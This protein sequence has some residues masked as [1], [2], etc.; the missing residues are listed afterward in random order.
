MFRKHE[1]IMLKYSA[2]SIVMEVLGIIALM[3][4][5]CMAVEMYPAVP[6]SFPIEFGSGGEAV[7]YAPRSVAMFHPIIAVIIYVIITGLCLAVRKAT[8]PDTPCPR[9][10]AVL[11]CIALCKTVYLL[12]ELGVTYCNMN[13]IPVFAWLM[14]TAIGAGAVFVIVF[15]LHIVNIGKK[16]KNKLEGVN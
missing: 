3:V 14:P 16:N 15:G 13:M 8:P 1:K 4:M 12:H 11:N 9:V 6:E 2:F 5:L 7:R 10:A